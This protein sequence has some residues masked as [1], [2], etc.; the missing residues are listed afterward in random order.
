MDEKDW[1]GLHIWFPAESASERAVSV[2]RG[3][4]ETISEV[5][6]I[7]EA[8]QPNLQNGFNYKGKKNIE[9]PKGGG[10][11]YYLSG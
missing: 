8:H 7:N 4:K 11:G 9:A 3:M 6:K 10:G 1:K 5:R 2:Q